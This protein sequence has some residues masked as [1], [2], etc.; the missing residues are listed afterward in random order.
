[1]E[2]FT[3]AEIETSLE[4]V[5]LPLGAQVRLLPNRVKVRCLVP[6]DEFERIRLGDFRLVVDFADVAEDQ[7][8]VIPKLLNAPE[9]ARNIRI[10][11][12]YVSYV[13]TQL[14]S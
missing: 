13:R 1:V 2:R 10:E 12:G 5:N 14:G 9:G 3:E 4:A 11:P 6:L 8:F 7:I